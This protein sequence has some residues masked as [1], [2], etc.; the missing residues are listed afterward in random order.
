M[1]TLFVHVLSIGLVVALA[2]LVR[3]ANF[4][5]N[6][7]ADRIELV[8]GDH[9]IATYVYHDPEIPRPYFAHLHGPG[10]VRVSR[11]HPPVEGRDKTDHPTFHPGLWLAFGDLSGADFWRNMATVAH[12]R[13]LQPAL[14][15][16]DKI[17]WAVENRYLPANAAAG[18]ICSEVC[19]Y[20]LYATDI[21]YLLT[22]DSTFYGDGEFWFGDQEEMGLGVRVATPLRVET[23]DAALPPPT[24]IILD[25]EGRRNASQ[26]WGKSAKWVDYSGI[27]DGA[28]AGVA[29]YCHPKNFR[30]TYFH[31][32]D[33]GFL[34]ANA[35]STAA[36]DLGPATTTVVQPGETLRLRYGVLLHAGQPLGSDALDA[37]WAEYLRVTNPC[38][39]KTSQENSRITG[40]R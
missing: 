22:W 21:G 17:A 9:A 7:K 24:G 26:V 12:V 25:S 2:P 39:A 19:R 31:A 3:G 40:P 4:K 37:G 27:L 13:M 16:D 34:A 1:N 20:E 32:R 38:K 14:V 8:D 10:G 35:F 5:V 18:P 30:K 29:I 6:G 11:N 36:F 15:I 23:G 28:A 33:Y